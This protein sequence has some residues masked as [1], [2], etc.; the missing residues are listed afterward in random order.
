MEEEKEPKEKDSEYIPLYHLEK[1][2]DIYIIPGSFSQVGEF[3]YK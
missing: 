2:K 1:M 3:Y